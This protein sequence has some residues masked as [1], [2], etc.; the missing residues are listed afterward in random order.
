MFSPFV[1]VNVLHAWNDF[2]LH[3]YFAGPLFFST[4]SHRRTP[5]T[6]TSALQST[7]IERVARWREDKKKDGTTPARSRTHLTG[8]GIKKRRRRTRAFQCT[9]H[10]D[11]TFAT[12]SCKQAERGMREKE[13]GVAARAERSLNRRA[14]NFTRCPALLTRARTAAL[15]QR[16]WEY[17]IRHNIF[18]E[19]TT[20]KNWSRRRHPL[21]TLTRS[22]ETSAA[23]QCVPVTDHY[24]LRS[25]GVWRS[26]PHAGNPLLS[27]HCGR[28]T[29]PNI[30]LRHLL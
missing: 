21:D 25:P 17:S 30:L 14:V 2:F 1:F 18:Q 28:L 5:K 19:T 10:L 23:Q 8:K 24:C 12:R 27:R 29:P 16:T 3:F 9:L 22:R 26:D 11:H 7:W 15:K 6:Y 13:G 20:K 4:G